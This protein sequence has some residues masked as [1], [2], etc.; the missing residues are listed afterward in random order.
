M[1]RINNKNNSSKNELIRI[2]LILIIIFSIGIL[3]GVSSYTW[4]YTNKINNLNT[5]SSYTVDAHVEVTEYNAGLNGDSDALK[6]GKV[7]LGAS[8]TRFLNIYSINESIVKIEASGNISQ[9]LSV[10]KNNFI[11]PKNSND[12]ITFNLDVPYDVAIGNYTGIIK[13]IFIYK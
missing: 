7:P 11:I 1:K 8:S 12:T 9:F 3:L 5:I 4:Y 2:S 10:D 13:V 6:F